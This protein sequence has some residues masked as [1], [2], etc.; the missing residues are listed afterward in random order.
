M[1]LSLVTLQTLDLI[2]IAEVVIA[3]AD[4]QACYQ[5]SSAACLEVEEAE[6]AANFEEAGV[7]ANLEAVVVEVLHDQQ[8][9]GDLEEDLFLNAEYLF[10]G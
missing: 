5:R 9:V 2:P 6:V 3:M 8:P 4:D 10:R 7:A 1:L